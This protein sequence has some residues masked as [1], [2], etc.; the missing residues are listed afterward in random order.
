[1]GD[2]P[3][4]IEVLLRRVRPTGWRV[5]AARSWT[6]IRKYRAG[7]ALENAHDD[8]RR[9]VLGIVLHAYE[10]ACEML[11]FVRDRD[12]NHARAETIHRTLE[13]N[14]ARSFEREYGYRLA[15]VGGVAC[16]NLEGWLLC[17]RGVAHTDDMKPAHAERDLEAAG[18]ELK[19]TE[20]YVAIAESA[21]LPTGADSLPSWLSNAHAAF[22][23]LIDGA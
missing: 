17:L 5:A 1:M 6:S 23:R 15:I 8:D 21:A 11:A 10:E 19:S 3:G 13:A 4:V 18:V 22:C 20:Q 12:D 7:S 16:P 9:N 14:P 2:D